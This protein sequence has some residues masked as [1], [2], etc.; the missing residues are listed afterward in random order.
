[1]LG[2]RHAAAGDD[3]GGGGRD[4]E[5]ALGVA[6][7]AAGVDGTLGRRDGGHVRA[8]G[9]RS[10]GDLL[11]RLTANAQRHQERA[12]LGLGRLAAHQGQESGLGPLGAER[13]ATREH[14]ERGAKL[15]RGAG[16]VGQHQ[17]VSPK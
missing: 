16:T 6:A 14:T 2:H 3:E 15:G 9:P 17:T 1:M 11:D 13:R 7:G 4:V 5:R 12:D 10:P 8:H